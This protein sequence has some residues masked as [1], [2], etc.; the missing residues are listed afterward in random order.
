MEREQGHLWTV[1]GV[2]AERRQVVDGIRW[3]YRLWEVTFPNRKPLRIGP[4]AAPCRLCRALWVS[5]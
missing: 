3:D 4:G 5:R 1:S 2:K